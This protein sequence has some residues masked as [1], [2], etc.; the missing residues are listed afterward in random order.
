[1]FHIS[2]CET[3]VEELPAV[4]ED[5]PQCRVDFEEVCREADGRCAKVPRRVCV[6]AAELVTKVRQT[7]RGNL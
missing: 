2:V 7:D 5:V 3:R 4:E 6:L 1:M